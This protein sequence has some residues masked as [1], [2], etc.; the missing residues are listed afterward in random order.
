ML[1]TISFQDRCLR[2]KDG[3]RERARALLHAHAIKRGVG[4]EERD[5]RM[6]AEET[7]LNVGPYR[8]EVVPMSRGRQGS[9]SPR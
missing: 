7:P 5:I 8:L 2:V 6:G 1:R 4:G 3:K 9:G